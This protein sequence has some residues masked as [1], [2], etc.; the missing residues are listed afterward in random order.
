[1]CGEKE[2]AFILQ[3]PVEFVIR[4]LMLELGAAAVFVMRCSVL[5]SAGEEHTIWTR[6]FHLRPAGRLNT[7]CALMHLSWIH[8]DPRARRIRA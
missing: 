7:L 3:R 2:G 4:C 1:M 8:E 5:E 6:R